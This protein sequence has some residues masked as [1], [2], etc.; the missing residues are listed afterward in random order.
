MPNEL[1]IGGDFTTVTQSNGHVVPAIDFAVL[2]A[3]TGDVIF[4]PAL[5][6]GPS[7]SVTAS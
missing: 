6:A 4:A 7:N 2:N 3:T 5:T 1:A